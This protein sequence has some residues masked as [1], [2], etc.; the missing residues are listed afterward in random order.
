MKKERPQKENPQKQTLQKESIENSEY[1]NQ[2]N[3]NQLKKTVDLSNLPE[4]KGYDFEKKFNL[5]KFISA[6]STTGIQATNL[7]TA[8]TITNAMIREDAKIFLSFTSNMISSGIREI[9]TYLVKHKMVH[10]I[11]TSAGGIEE[12]LIKARTGF[13]LGTFNAKGESLLSVGVSRIGN[14]YTTDEQYAYLEFLINDVFNELLKTGEEITPSGICRMAGK[15]LEKKDKENGYKKNSSYLYWAYKNNIPVFCPG[16][17]DGTI[18][19][20]AYFIKMNN[21][22]LKIDVLS[23]HQKIIDFALNSEKTGAIILGGGTAKHYILDANI[24]REGFDY[25]VYITTATEH[26]ASDSGGNQEEAIS[27]AKIKPNA[28]RVI[29]HCD[30]SIAFPLL[31][32]GSFGRKKKTGKN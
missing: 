8:I 17:I 24:F 25:A 3:S 21:K 13:R 27:W 30:A 1:S 4:I 22:D 26:D 12:D 18:G 19:N 6:Y 15:M 28:P 14:I 10:A 31:V 5:N 7:G 16:L 29:V 23:D 32:A 11:V 20:I 2:L 9:I